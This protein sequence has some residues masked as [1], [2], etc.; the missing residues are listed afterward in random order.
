MTAAVATE[1]VRLPI[2]RAAATILV[3]FRRRLALAAISHGPW[4]SGI[5]ILC[6]K[7]LFAE[8]PVHRIRRCEMR[9]PLM[10]VTSTLATV[11]RVCFRRAANNR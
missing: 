9:Q 11:A 1:A 2:T 8:C 3:R 5:D 4:I 10:H 6:E 7:R